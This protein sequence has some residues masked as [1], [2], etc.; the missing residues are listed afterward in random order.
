M[1]LE[2][3]RKKFKKKE[4]EKLQCKTKQKMKILMKNITLFMA[5]LNWILFHP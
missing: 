5:G 1:H 3:I 2:H 4:K